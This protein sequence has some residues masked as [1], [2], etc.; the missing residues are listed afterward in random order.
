ME[1]FA[2]LDGMQK[3]T[4]PEYL[5]IEA[6]GTDAICI[7]YVTVTGAAGDERTWHAGYMKSCTDGSDLWYP[8]PDTVPGTDYRPGCVWL[9]SDDRF[10]QGLT[11]HLPSF[12]FP[13][14]KKAEKMA[15]QYKSFPDTLCKAP[16][17]Q[18]LYKKQIGRAHV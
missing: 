3:T 17:R 7:T 15:E 13:E 4:S 5:T 11:V 10:L 1:D 12:G 14:V 2:V 18:A 8:S 16:G 9:S 6:A